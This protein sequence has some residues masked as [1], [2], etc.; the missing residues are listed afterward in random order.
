MHTPPAVVVANVSPRSANEP[1]APMARYRAI[2]PRDAYLAHVADGRLARPG[3]EPCDDTLFVK[4]DGRGTGGHA[5]RREHR[6]V[7]RLELE[8]ELLDLIAFLARRRR[9]ERIEELE[10]LVAMGLCP[11]A[12]RVP[13]DP[14]RG[15]D[16]QDSDLRRVLNAEPVGDSANVAVDSKD[17][18]SRLARSDGPGHAAVDHR[19]AG[20]PPRRDHRDLISPQL[21]MIGSHVRVP[22]DPRIDR[23]LLLPTERH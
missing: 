4:R 11:R 3:T 9:G 12:S 6:L 2:R 21:G 23:G 17:A 5:E 19:P 8:E 10:E 16:E 18:S 20:R 22:G 1:R 7:A 14:S 13:G 15:I